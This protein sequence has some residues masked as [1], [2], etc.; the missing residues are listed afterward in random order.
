[1]N[2]LIVL[3]V[4]WYSFGV[5]SQSY[6][7]AAGQPGSSAI[8]KDSSAIIGWATGV[9][10]QRGLLDIAQ[11]A[12]GI[13]TYGEDSMA[14]GAAEGDGANVVSLGDGGVATL[15]FSELIF[16]GEGPDFAVFENGFADNYMEFAHVEVSSDGLNFF[17]F[18]SVSETPL[19]SQMNNFSLGDCRYIN[20]LA[21]K[22]RQGYGTP[23]DLEEL[24][25]IEGLDINSI[26]HVRLVD[27]VGSVDPQWG[28]M[29]SEGS[30]IN[31]PYPTAF[32]SGGFDLDAVGI[33]NAL[34]LGVN[35]QEINVAIYPNPTSNTFNV[36][37]SGSF[38]LRIY[39]LLGSE[40]LVLVGV[41]VLH[42]N[43]ELPDGIYLCKLV[44]DKGVVER[45]IRIQ[46]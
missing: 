31:D 15:I 8:Y 33:I 1:M 39:D 21:G 14:L 42:V 46:N 37:F 11:P 26:S 3:I 18:P 13:A 32:E 34:P 36:A 12:L 41:N 35:D 22:Y 30:L 44:S 7:P 9:V 25:G 4:V 40:K 45:K 38:E 19:D 27:V 17:R 29:D 43:T 16:N 23:F 6:A 2:K 24:E 20:N 28:S 5:C 10:I